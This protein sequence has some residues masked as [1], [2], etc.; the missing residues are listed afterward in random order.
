M[1]AGLHNGGVQCTIPELACLGLF[2]GVTRKMDVCHLHNPVL[3]FG[4]QLFWSHP[5]NFLP[6]STAQR[7]GRHQQLLLNAT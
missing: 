5:R 2:N 6:R 1:G 3:G 7:K 4:L